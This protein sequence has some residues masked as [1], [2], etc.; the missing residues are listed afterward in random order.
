MELRAVKLRERDALVRRAIAHELR[1]PMR[2]VEPDAHLVRDLNADPLALCQLALALEATFDLEV[3]QEDL[4]G[5]GTVRDVI[6]Y[7]EARLR[8]R[9]DGDGR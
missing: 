1:I 2:D 5:F 9:T 8:D 4:Q 6:E 7:V 3:L